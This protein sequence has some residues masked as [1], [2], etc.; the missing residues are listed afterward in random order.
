[1]KE[2]G[3]IRVV[4]IGLPVE[5][6]RGECRECSNLMLG[7]RIGGRRGQQHNRANRGLRVGQQNNLVGG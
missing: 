3:L 2:R 5:G 6:S 4:R 7:C 1:M